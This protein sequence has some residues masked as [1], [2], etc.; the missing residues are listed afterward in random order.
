M[1]SVRACG[2]IGVLCVIAS[3]TA[4]L[5]RE[6][7]PLSPCLI[8]TVN[9][10]I[11]VQNVDTVDVLFMVDNSGS[12]REEQAALV[13]ELPEM[14]RVLSS[15]DRDNDGVQDFRPVELR[16][17]VVS[18]DLGL[19]GIGG[20]PGN[21]ACGADLGDNALLQH[22][23]NPSANPA[24][25]CQLSYPAPFLGFSPQ[26]GPGAA[27]EVQRIANDFACISTLGT[28]GCGFEQQLESSLK[29]LWPSDHMVL[30]QD[31]RAALGSIQGFVADPVTQLG[32]NGNGDPLG[33]NAGFLHNNVEQGLSLIAVVL[34]TDEEDCSSWNLGHLVHEGL[35]GPDDPLRAQHPNLRCFMNKQNLFPVQRYINGLKA[36][37]PGRE[38]LVVFAA[39][40]GVLPT[41]VDETALANVDFEQPAQVNAFYDR[42]LAHESMI[43]APNATGDNLNTSCTTTV[44]GVLQKAYPP[45]RIVEVAKGFGA[46]GI[47]QSICQESF[48][49]AMNRIIETIIGN[50]PNVC[51]PRKLVRN[52]EGKVDCRVVWELP[53]VSQV[54]PTHCADPRF[55]GVLSAPASGRSR[56]DDDRAICEVHQLPVGPCTPSGAADDLCVRGIGPIA[57]EQGWYY[58]DFSDD[59]QICPGIEKQ[60]VSFSPGANPATGVVVRLECTSEV[61]SLPT[62]RT[63]LLNPAASRNVGDECVEDLDCSVALSS[64]ESCQR[65]APFRLED[66]GQ[67]LDVGMFCHDNDRRCV[68]A[69]LSNA[70]CPPAWQCDIKG[71]VHPLSETQNHPICVNPTCGD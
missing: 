3:T 47:V 58:D 48:A 35:L 1:R 24:L 8:T 4:C 32:G 26:T 44:G 16:L 34:V 53:K 56:T 5:D 2:G 43:E 11:S 41:L 15:G 22:A 28:T 71:I 60:R 54:A 65:G 66:N 52:L 50:L 57:S 18:S 27:A 37:R 23:S 64:T 30:G 68:K 7:A 20:G 46:N 6:L 40:T 39:I 29:A 69:C 31:M 17:G 13:R 45:R 55:A 25:N 70:D 38:S 33:A 63:D 49:P 21:P 59:V 62:L 9:D 42:I 61:Q 36:L 51:L 19:P 14:V 12:M 67:C 10:T